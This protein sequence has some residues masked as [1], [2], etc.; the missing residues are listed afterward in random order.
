LFISN[1]TVETH[2]K[3]YN[4]EIKEK[5]HYQFGKFALK[6]FNQSLNNVAKLR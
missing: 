1:N 6:Q 2:R 3:K 4:E 5:K